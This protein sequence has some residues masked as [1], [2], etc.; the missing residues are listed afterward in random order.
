MRMMSVGRR[1][2]KNEAA[3]NIYPDIAGVSTECG[4]RSI[5]GEDLDSI[6]D[7]CDTKIWS[8]IRQIHWYS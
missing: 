3:R 5:P 2:G 7:T 8:L 6:L 4:M 1:Q